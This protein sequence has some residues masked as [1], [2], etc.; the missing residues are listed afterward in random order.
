MGT[1]LLH[2]PMKATQKNLCTYTRRKAIWKPSSDCV[3]EVVLALRIGY[4][5]KSFRELHEAAKW[6]SKLAEGTYEEFFSK[7]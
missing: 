2:M 6:Y 7:N 4:E 1:D 3:P 5:A